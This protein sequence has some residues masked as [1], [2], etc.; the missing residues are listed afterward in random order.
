MLDGVS[1]LQAGTPEDLTVV[2]LAR[3]LA[4]AR[5]EGVFARHDKA[6]RA[7]GQAVALAALQQPARGQVLPECIF[8]VHCVQAVNDDVLADLITR[9]D[10]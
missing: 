1:L 5:A 10:S 2:S 9:V 7:A 6:A 8:L 3:D 4:E